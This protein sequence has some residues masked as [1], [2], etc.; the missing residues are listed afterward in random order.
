MQELLDIIKIHSPSTQEEA[1][2]QYLIK[3]YAKK[4]DIN[5]SND[6]NL[7]I[8]EG[9]NT[10]I[11]SHIDHHNFG[12]NYNPV[13]TEEGVKSKSLD[14]AVGTY[15]NSS[16]IGE[17]D[18]THCFTVEEEINYSGID[19]VI[20]KL[21]PKQLIILDTC[22]IEYFTCLSFDMPVLLSDESNK[23]LLKKLHT[24]SELDGL[25]SF[26]NMQQYESEAKHVRESS[27]VEIIFLNIPI[28]NMHSSEEVVSLAAVKR[29]RSTLL[30]IIN[31][32]QTW[33]TSSSL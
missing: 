20:K 14:N 13:I 16:L 32:M 5:Y 4:I 26:Y 3:N 2:K 7:Y 8:G 29:T 28:K 33:Q 22:P 19:E 17:I 21:N 23:D 31:S 27:D 25:C 10:V 12:S 9:D 11:C 18:A 24:E 1:L 30:K 6:H 15:I